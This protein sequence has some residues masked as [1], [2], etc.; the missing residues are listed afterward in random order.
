MHSTRVYTVHLEYHLCHGQARIER[1]EIM[2]GI[3]GSVLR[4]EWKGERDVLL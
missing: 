4:Y 1:L 2:Y 3:L